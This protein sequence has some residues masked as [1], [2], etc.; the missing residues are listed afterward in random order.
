MQDPKK[1]WRHKMWQN[2]AF[3]ANG[4]VPMWEMIL[5]RSTALHQVKSIN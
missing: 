4:D 3:D 5:G 2:N 1:D